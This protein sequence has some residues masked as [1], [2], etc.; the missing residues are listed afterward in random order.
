MQRLPEALEWSARKQPPP[1]PRFTR[2]ITQ[3][4]TMTVEEIRQRAEV[5]QL[6]A[7]VIAFLVSTF[8]SCFDGTVPGEWVSEDAPGRSDVNPWNVISPGTNGRVA[9]GQ[10]WTSVHDEL[11]PLMGDVSAEEIDRVFD[12]FFEE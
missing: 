1:E 11:A 5:M 12:A 3:T 6:S 8:E 7:A 9:L 4:R 2:T 10:S